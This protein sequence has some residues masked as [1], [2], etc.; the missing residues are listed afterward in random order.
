METLFNQLNDVVEQLLLKHNVSHK[1]IKQK[2]HHGI[3]ILSENLPKQK[4]LFNGVHGGYGYSRQFESYICDGS[5]TYTYPS[6]A[7]RISH[8]KSVENFGNV[9]KIKYPYIAKLIA[10]HN[11]YHLRDV[12]SSVNRIQFVE[13]E[14]VSISTVSTIINDSDEELFG[15]M[16]DVQYVCTHNFKL[17][18]VRKYTKQSLLQY[19]QDKKSKHE[20]E[21][22]MSNCRIKELIGDLSNWVLQDYGVTH[23][24]EET[25]E[26]SLL[27][28][29]KKKWYER[30]VSGQGLQRFTFIDAIEHYG[31][32]HFAIWKCQFHYSDEVMRF[33]IK[34]HDLF[35]L[36]CLDS[37]SDLEMGLL[38][39]SGPYCKLCVGEAPQLLSWYIGE[40]DGLESIVDVP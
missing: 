3:S 32:A 5:D 7:E 19:V 23:F 40:Y 25:L 20:H 27:W 29:E 34:N 24:E 9:C 26:D 36:D 30:M 2:I 4:V 35:D 13:K 33:L 31:E 21:I 38:C 39:A 15:S 6:K 18:Q 22:Q 10:I 28:Y 11:H 8:V 17:E 1:T 16:E 14:L 12:F 37:C